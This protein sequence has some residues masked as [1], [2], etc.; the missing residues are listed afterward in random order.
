M[1]DTDTNPEGAL[2]GSL[3]RYR[4][5]VLLLAT[6]AVLG[7]L[8]LDPT[9]QTVLTVGVA[10]AAVAS[11]LNVWQGHLGE[12]SFGHGAFVAVGAYAWTVARFR[13]ELPPAPA[14]LVTLVVT[15]AVCAVVGLAV[16]QLSHFGS[17]IVTLFLAFVVAAGLQSSEFT[18]ITGSQAGLLVP[19]LR[20]LGLNLGAERGLYYLG[21]GFLG[22]VLLL[23][24]NYVSSAR[25]RAL[26]LIRANDQVASLLGVRVKRVKWAAFV[27]TGVGAGLGGVVLAQVLT[28]VTPDSFALHISITAVAMIVVGG[29]GTTVGPVLGAFFFGALPTVFQSSP[30]NQALY[31][32][33][34]FLVFL[35]L[36]P[37]GLVG[38]GVGLFRAVAHGRSGGKAAPGPLRIGGSHLVAEAAF[39]PAVPPAPSPA[40]E[41]TRSPVAAVEVIDVDVTFAG[42]HALRKVT[43]ILTAGRTHALIGPNGAGKSTLINAITGIQPVASGAIKVFGTDVTRLHPHAIRRAGVGR[44][45]QNP[46]LVDDLSVLENVR[47]GLFSEQQQ[48]LVL[49]LL[50]GSLGRRSQAAAVARCEDALRQVGLAPSLWSQRA[51]GVSLADRK[52]VDLARALVSQPRVLLLDEPT[53]GL[54]EDEM[55]VVENALLRLRSTGQV[56]ILLIA[57]HVAFVRRVADSV[58]V[59]DAGEVLASG[60]PDEVTNDSSVLEAFVGTPLELRRSRT[61]QKVA[62]SADAGTSSVGA[63]PPTTPPV[64]ARSGSG[65][66]V[67]SLSA[68]YGLARVLDDVSLC[69]RRGELVGLAGRNGVGKT[70][71][72]RSLSGISGRAG[73]TAAIDGRPLPRRPEAAARAGLIHVPEGR[74][75]IPSLTVLENLRVG[76]LAV[77]GRLTEDRLDCTV[78]RFPTL[79]RLLR[80]QAGLLSGGEQQ[81]LAIARGLVADPSILMIDE[82]SLGLSPKAT[83]EA[84]EVVSAI[85]DRGGPGVLVVDQNIKT[86]A[87]V[88]D[89][90][91][92]LKDGTAVEVESH[93]DSIQDLQ[94]VY[95]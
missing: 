93:R 84:L 17:A 60:S 83:S 14:L 11:T 95:F 57:H 69:V 58:T 7:L 22:I 66:V 26:R 32:S 94:E 67:A 45:F 2:G 23:T 91:Y 70:T 65:L 87:S 13:A 21:L 18:S 42:V 81:M 51:G 52:L 53:A 54:G 37:T 78:D 47:L 35:V 6:L 55:H 27:Y 5:P 63:L 59:L 20:L 41:G 30:V 73:G 28:V 44:T 12:M 15:L 64:S 77:G 76:A 80:R 50:R 85:T 34:T 43:D 56:S 68:G 36:A 16:V 92:V 31:A 25:G 62:V 4:T 49:D 61:A 19:E 74:G 38:L 33:I 72:L 75:V 29:Q 1:S 46:S 24:A 86:L 3:R 90:L 79:G 89:R 8:P 10:W 88:C 82:L 71:L 48:P 9:W 40:D 39:A